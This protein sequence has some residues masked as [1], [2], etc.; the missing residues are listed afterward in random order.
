MKAI[1][2]HHGLPSLRQ[3]VACRC[4][5]KR[6]TSGRLRA[7]RRSPKKTIRDRFEEKYIPEPNSG[8][9]IWTASVN[10]KGYGLFSS[11]GDD[12]AHRFAYKHFRGPIPD[13]LEV[14]H[15]CDNPPCVNP[16]HLFLGTHLENMRDCSRKG[17]MNPRSI[18]N[19]LERARRKS[20]KRFCKRGH[21]LK[22]PN[23][24]TRAGGGRTCK[25]CRAKSNGQYRIRKQNDRNC[26]PAL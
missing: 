24:Y 17:R 1:P 15:S 8:C 13:R 7:M 14:C 25:T 26:Q 12:Y 6:I 20:Q 19:V 9:W 5:R 3:C 22:G 21:P 10:N 23:V 4:E 2:C 11:N 18:L 16:R